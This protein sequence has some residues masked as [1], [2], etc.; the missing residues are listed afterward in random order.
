ML[1][2]MLGADHFS[3][4]SLIRK[5]HIDDERVHQGELL[6][7]DLVNRVVREEITAVDPST[8]ILIDGFPR[9]LTQKNWL[10]QL[11]QKEARNDVRVVHLE[12]SDDEID[13]RLRSRARE[14][15]TP[16][17]IA[18]RKRIFMQEVVPVIASYKE[19][20]VLHTIPGEGEIEEIQANIVKELGL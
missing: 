3:I 7:D 20:G 4:G 15:D 16:H 13:S 12:V 5:K 6:P 11:L 19:D 1:A 10:D 17:A 18:L 2:R 9:R 8:V 14:D